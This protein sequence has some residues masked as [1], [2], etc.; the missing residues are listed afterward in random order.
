M[1][2]HHNKAN[3]VDH[4]KGDRGQEVNVAHI[5]EVTKSGDRAAIQCL[6][7]RGKGERGERGERGR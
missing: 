3:W 4:A 2:L 7:W 1:V 5:V 6:N